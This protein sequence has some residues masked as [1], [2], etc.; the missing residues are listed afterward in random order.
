MD[1]DVHGLFAFVSDS[2]RSDGGMSSCRNQPPVPH[3]PSAPRQALIWHFAAQ[4]KK[5]NLPGDL[6]NASFGP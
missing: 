3:A 1:I 6:G 4:R 5:S 2:Y